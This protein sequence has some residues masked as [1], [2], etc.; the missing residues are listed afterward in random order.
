M[1]FL[2]RLQT[3]KL[4]YPSFTSSSTLDAKFICWS[5]NMFERKWEL[6]E[7]RPHVPLSDGNS[8]LSVT[9]MT[10]QARPEH[11]SARDNLN[12]SKWDG[13]L[14]SKEKS[15]ILRNCPHIFPAG[16]NPIHSSKDKIS[17]MTSLNVIHYLP[18]DLFAVGNTLIL[19]ISIFHASS[20]PWNQPKNKWLIVVC[21]DRHAG[22][23]GRSLSGLPV[24]ETL[25]THQMLVMWPST[26]WSQRAFGCSA[27][28]PG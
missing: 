21:F 14:F 12:V 10:V 16:R 5:W 4:P 6:K 19:H 25:S 27:S 2:K 9:A 24:K 28:R 3:S 1:D 13:K 17:S 26:S 20:G 15:L 8:H 22:R 11:L 7:R 23:K 18:N